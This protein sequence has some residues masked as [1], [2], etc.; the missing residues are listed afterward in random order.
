M[1]LLEKLTEL[2]NKFIQILKRKNPAGTINRSLPVFAKKG[3]EPQPDPELMIKGMYPDS[4]EAEEPEPE[5]MDLF[6]K[7]LLQE[8]KNDIALQLDDEYAIIKVLD[9]VSAEDLVN[10]LRETLAMIKNKKIQQQQMVVV[11][12]S[13]GVFLTSSR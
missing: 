4:L 7:D 6:G 12:Y 13:Y 10:E 3:A 1:E 5:N 2:F 9:E 11:Q 8:L